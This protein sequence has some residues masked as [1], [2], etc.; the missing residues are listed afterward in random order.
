MY[1]LLHALVAAPD[2]QTL[3]GLRDHAWL[4][5]VFVEGQ[6]LAQV[7]SLRVKDVDF[8]PSGARI[9]LPEGRHVVLSLETASALALWLDVARLPAGCRV[10]VPVTVGGVVHRD[11]HLSVHGLRV[12][13]REYGGQ[14]VLDVIDAEQEEP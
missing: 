8:G 6:T 10:L 2:R 12:R 13:L 3:L 1:D 11:S 7:V 14:A 5:L 4:R 9:H